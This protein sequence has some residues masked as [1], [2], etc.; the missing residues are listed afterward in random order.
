MPNALN[1]LVSISSQ[2]LAPGV[3]ANAA[4]NPPELHALLAAKNG[5]FA[6]ESALRVFPSGESAHSYSIAEWNSP[7]LW[8]HAY[9]ALADGLFFFAEDIF[10]CQFCLKNGKVY[11]FDPETGELTFVADH[12]EGWAQE[13]L[14]QFEVLTGYPLAH[15]W[16]A[17]FGQ[18]EGRDRLMP[19]LPFVCGGEFSVDNLAVI[20]AARAMRS[21]GN[22]ASQIQGLPD[23]AEITFQVVD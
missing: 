13:I 22:F 21:R 19:K 3:T 4:G 16:Q 14:D 6:F 11:S 8:R 7:G 18:V 10:G 1:K 2:P 23:G 20:D 5:F 12:L 9:G 15:A 17:E